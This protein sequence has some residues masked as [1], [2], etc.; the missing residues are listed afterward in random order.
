MFALRQ[1][2][3]RVDNEK[4]GYMY[5]FRWERSAALEHS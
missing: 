3:I 4:V 5:G 1:T 2:F